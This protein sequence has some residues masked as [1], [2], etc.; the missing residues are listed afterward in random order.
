MRQVRLLP[1]SATWLWSLRSAD[2]KFRGHR[3]LRNILFLVFTV[4]GFSSLIY[5]SIWTHLR[6]QMLLSILA[7]HSSAP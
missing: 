5:E 2:R 3:T 1:A 4:S 7:A 6:L